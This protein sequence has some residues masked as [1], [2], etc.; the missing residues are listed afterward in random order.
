LSCPILYAEVTLDGTLG[1]RIALEGPDYAIDAKFGQQHG[2]NLFHSFDHFNL[3]SNESATFSGPNNIS[4]ILSRVT[5]G[6]PSHING[7]FR[8]TIPNADVYFFNPYGILFGKEATLDVQG[9]F[10]ASTADTLRFSDG[11]EFNARNPENSLLTVAPVE[12]FGFLTEKPQSL[13]IEKS[14]LMDASILPV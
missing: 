13:S 8:A 1:P 6:S 9:S 4:N 10:H 2:N 7:L 5:G 12:T 3:N 14:E 11:N